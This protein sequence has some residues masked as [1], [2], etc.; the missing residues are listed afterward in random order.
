MLTK[1]SGFEGTDPKE[2]FGER[3]GIQ[4]EAFIDG[5]AGQGMPGSKLIRH[6]DSQPILRSQYQLIMAKAP[7]DEFEIRGYLLH[8]PAM[9]TMLRDGEQPHI[10]I[11]EDKKLRAWT[12]PDIIENLPVTEEGHPAI[13]VLGGYV[14][15]RADMQGPELIRYADEESVGQ[16]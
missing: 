12:P 16:A 8:L 15:L 4:Y 9:G 7:E 3:G 2:I 14:T 13:P 1:V 11:C 5:L 6:V 10:V